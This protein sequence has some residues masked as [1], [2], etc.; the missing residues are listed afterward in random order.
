[1]EKLM[2]SYFLKGIV[3]F[4]VSVFTTSVAN[5]QWPIRLDGVPLLADGTA[6]LDAPTPR[7]FD[8]KPDFSGVWNKIRNAPGGGEQGRPVGEPFEPPPG[9][10]PYATFWDQGFGF[11]N[12]LPYLPW[13][14]EKR[15]ERV[16]NKGIENPDSYCLPLGHMQF[17]THGQPREIVQSPNQIVMIY[18]ASAGIRQI[19]MD[20][21]PLPDN[22]PM[23][24]WYGYSVGRWEG[25]T[26]VVE[27]SNFRGDGWVDFY[28]SPSTDQLKI[29]ERFTRV[30]YGKMEIDI[31][32]D[33]PGA[34]T[35][36]FTVRVEHRILP[37]DNLIEWVCENEQSIQYFNQ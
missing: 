20:G 27:T 36:P 34:Y 35:E 37:G 31:T 14:R 23:E 5:A 25:D 7:T 16:A 4:T 17:H 24:Y 32:I 8:G 19:F 6:D 28:G 9:V 30:S 29:T 2:K 33:D 10:P 12:G 1:M 15:E 18:E 11:E 21:R 26:L 3:M 13:A 22:D